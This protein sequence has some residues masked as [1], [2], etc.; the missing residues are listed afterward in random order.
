[1]SKDRLRLVIFLA[2]VA[3]IT[4]GPVEEYE[5]TDYSRPLI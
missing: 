4:D 1:M 2:V 3:F 5:M